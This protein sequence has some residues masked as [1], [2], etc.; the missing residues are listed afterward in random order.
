[1]RVAVDRYRRSV[2]AGVNALRCAPTRCAG[3]GVDTGS[4]PGDQVFIDGMSVPFCGR[5]PRANAD[6]AAGTQL[7]S[8]PI[9]ISDSVR[10]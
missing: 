9:K 8:E 5:Q 3:F 7:T 6:C 1:V 10:F 2:L 4:A